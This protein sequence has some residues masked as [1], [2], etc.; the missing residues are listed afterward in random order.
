MRSVAAVVLALGLAATAGSAT[1][2][3]ASR[4]F[5]ADYTVIAR[6]VN[7]GEFN[8]RFNQTGNSYTASATREMTGLAAAALG[9][10]QDYR[11]SVSGSV[12]EDGSLRPA[13]YEHQGGRRRED[14]Q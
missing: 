10:S 7:A 6:G 5:A 4:T 3:S 1:A 13:A 11:Y 9:R 14:R 2:Q 8:F 12:A